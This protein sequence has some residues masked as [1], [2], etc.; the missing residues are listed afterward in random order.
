MTK[1]E[2]RYICANKGC[3]AKSFVPEENAE[4]ACHYH[5]GEVVFHDLKKY[6]TCCHDKVKAALDWDEFMKMP[7]CA[8]SSHQI[9]Y[10]KLLK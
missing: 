6:W 8:E 9:K 10:K 1:D 7:T 4:D 5:P 3:A 2:K